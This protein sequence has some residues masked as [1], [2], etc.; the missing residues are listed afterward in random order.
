MRRVCI[1]M[2]SNSSFFFCSLFCFSCEWSKHPAHSVVSPAFLWLF[3]VRFHSIFTVSFNSSLLFQQQLDHGF[4]TCF[5]QLQETPATKWEYSECVYRIIGKLVVKYIV[6]LMYILFLCALPNNGT[7]KNTVSTLLEEYKTAIRIFNLF[8]LDVV[9][10]FSL[11]STESPT[12]KNLFEILSLTV[13]LGE[14][15]IETPF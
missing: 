8:K 2:R 5:I 14:I 10:I 9:K 4:S 1:S 6:H 15:S 7:L 13:I 3:L 11:N 12:W